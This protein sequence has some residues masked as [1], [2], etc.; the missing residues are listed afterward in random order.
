MVW[1][2]TAVISLAFRFL[3]SHT[4][5]SVYIYLQEV[6]V[7]HGVSLLHSIPQLPSLQM[8]GRVTI[9]LECPSLCP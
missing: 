1:G 4:Q 9:L 8:Q 3:V 6:N 5:T 7:Y 2:T